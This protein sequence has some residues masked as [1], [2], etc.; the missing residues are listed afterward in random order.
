ME[1]TSIGNQPYGNI[2]L[3]TSSSAC[4]LVEKS[5]PQSELA[6]DEHNMA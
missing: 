1:E 6:D 5:S 2:R 4:S 3:G